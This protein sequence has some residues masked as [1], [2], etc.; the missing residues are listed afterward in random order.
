ME[1]WM[2]GQIHEQLV[3]HPTAWYGRDLVNNSSWLVHLTPEDLAEIAAAVP[4]VKA[5]GLGAG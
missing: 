4:G 5:H 1:D 2:S 3:Q